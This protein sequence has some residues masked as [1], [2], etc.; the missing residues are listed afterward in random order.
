MLYWIVYDIVCLFWT[1]YSKVKAADSDM[2]WTSF[3]TVV[4]KQ[5]LRIHGRIE[6]GPAGDAG[7]DK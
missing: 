1:V 2:V 7:L 3:I 4:I 6:Y 5:K